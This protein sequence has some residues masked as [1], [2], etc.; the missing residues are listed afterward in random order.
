MGE[1]ENLS[2]PNS[3]FYRSGK[4]G[5]ERD[6][7]H[8]ILHPLSPSSAF[9]PIPSSVNDA[10]PVS[11]RAPHPALLFSQYF[12]VGG[13]PQSYI[14]HGK[15]RP[16]SLPADPQLSHCECCKA[17]PHLC[18]SIHHKLSTCFF[19]FYLLVSTKRATTRVMLVEQIWENGNWQFTPKIVL[20]KNSLLLE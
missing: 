5:P 16:L 10:N 19:M 3:L 9:T 15:G 14:W 13:L 7:P 6:D 17:S 2:S 12:W 1:T 20:N 18:P 8:L 11:L 4:W